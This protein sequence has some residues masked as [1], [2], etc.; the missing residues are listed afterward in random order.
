M[1]EV[2][3]TILLVEDDPDT[4]FLIEC[5]FEA[6]NLPVSVQS[7]KDGQEAINYLEGKELFANFERYP[8]PAILLANVNM[9][10]VSGFE[11]LAWIKKH[12]RLNK[13]PVVLMSDCDDP[14]Q[15]VEAAS[16][17]AHSYFVKTTSFDDLIDIVGKFILY[18]KLDQALVEVLVQG[19]SI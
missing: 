8:T 4:R 17:G 7:V 14:A 11:L 19:E 2:T 18:D 1:D 5:L 16:L 12:P 9:P 3:K 13:L 6:T 15:L 10:R